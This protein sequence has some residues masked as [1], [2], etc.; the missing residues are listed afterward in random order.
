M[1]AATSGRPATATTSP[2]A[3]SATAAATPTLCIGGA[4][5]ARQ[6]KRRHECK[7]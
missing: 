6:R 1:P 7:H 5:D 3:A 2:A 4:R